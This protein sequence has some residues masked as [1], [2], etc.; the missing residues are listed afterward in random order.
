LRD[1]ARSR[2]RLGLTANQIDPGYWEA[3]RGARSARIATSAAS[4]NSSASIPL[5]HSEIP[6]D[7]DTGVAWSSS[8]RSTISTRSA[9][10]RAPAPSG[11]VSGRTDDEVV[12]SV[13][14]D[15]VGLPG[16]RHQPARALDQDPV[17]DLLPGVVARV[18]ETVDADEQ[19]GERLETALGA[20][21]LAVELV[22]Q[23]G[24][25]QAAG[26]RIVRGGTDEPQ[27]RA[28]VVE[29]QADERGVRRQRLECDLAALVGP[30]REP[31]R[32][33][34]GASARRPH[35]RQ[36]RVGDRLVA[37]KSSAGV[38]AVRIRDRLQPPP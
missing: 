38:G 37:A 20:P 7:A 3:R 26:E 5:L 21:D 10:A 23:R 6:M 15:E 28:G 11:C 31:A 13:A 12:A 36:Q 16:A 19:A 8:V 17:C 14:P 27:Q 24:V 18:L 29:P 35:G 4:I 25:R 1:S 2:S 30:G 34:P 33:R 32:E 9:S 22:H